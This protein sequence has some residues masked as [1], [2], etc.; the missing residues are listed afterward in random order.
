MEFN[1]A[2]KYRFLFLLMSS[3]SKSW[4]T[5]LGTTR[6]KYQSLRRFLPRFCW[7]QPGPSV[8][9]VSY[10]PLKEGRQAGS[11][12]VAAAGLVDVFHR[13]RRGERSKGGDCHL[14]PVYNHNA[15]ASFNCGT[16]VPLMWAA[17]T[18]SR[19]PNSFPPTNTA[20]TACDS[21]GPTSRNSAFS[22][23]LPPLCS[24][25]SYTVGPTPRL[26]KRRFTTW[27]MQHPLW[28]NTT[29]AFSAASLST[30]SIAIAVRSPPSLR[31]LSKS[32][33]PP[34]CNLWYECVWVCMLPPL[35]TWET[36]IFE[37]K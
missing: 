20:G 29:T 2:W 9:N 21:A 12:G 3:V 31:V 13:K 22:R 27:H 7:V 25:S 5:K 24:S 32:F 10:Q 34:G 16:R 4:I 11:T 33:L 26:Q 15:P 17:M 23:S 6:T 19:P 37:K 28:L 30:F 18:R 35:S 36:W 1:S 14:W 8:L